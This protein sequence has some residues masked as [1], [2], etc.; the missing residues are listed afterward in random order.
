MT[1]KRRTW[2]LYAVGAASAAAGLGWTL[3]PTAGPANQQP[4]PSADSNANPAVN[5][6]QSAALEGIDAAHPLWSSRFET[7]AGP[8]V[9]LSSFLG[10]PLLL[11]FWATWCPPCIK[12][13]PLLD[14]FQNERRAEGWRVL[15]LAVDSP[16]AVRDYLQRIPVKFEIGLA[17]MGGLELA[18][19]LGNPGGQL[20]FTVVFDRQGR[21]VE[22]KLG[23]VRDDDLTAW[24][25]SAT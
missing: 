2:A 9:A 20:P 8:E 10:Q 1:L 4:D 21:L 5:S 22:R 17:G 11:N 23:L 3:R 12:E 6:G 19:T 14:R 7:P 16:S 25:R 13:M 15:G 18:R 24:V